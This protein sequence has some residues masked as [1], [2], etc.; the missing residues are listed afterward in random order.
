MERLATIPEVVRTEAVP[1]PMMSTFASPVSLPEIQPQ[2]PPSFG[3]PLSPTAP[4]QPMVMPRALVRTQS[5]VGNAPF[6]DY[7]ERT[8]AMMR[9]PPHEPPIE[10]SR[11]ATPSIPIQTMTLGTG[12]E[13]ELA[14]QTTATSTLAVPQDVR[15][16]GL[17]L[18]MPEKYTGNQSPVVSGWLTKMERYFRLMKY[19]T[20]IWV[21]VIA[22]CITDAAQAW[23]DKELQDV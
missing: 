12:D 17:K 7:V 16:G 4:S 6:K 18:E 21:Y 2:G 11:T 19:P 1:A 13:T 8:I 14:L 10:R 3:A 9:A 5:G 15:I 23:L 22:T 20:D